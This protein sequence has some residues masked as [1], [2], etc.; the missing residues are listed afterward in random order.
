MWLLARGAKKQNS[1]RHWGRQAVF[2]VCV[3]DYLL[4]STKVDIMPCTHT[5]THTHTSVSNKES[6]FSEHSQALSWEWV[7]LQLS[8]QNKPFPE[9]LRYGQIYPA[10]FLP[11]ISICK[12]DSGIDL[13]ITQNT[14]IC[15][16]ILRRNCIRSTY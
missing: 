8:Q 16:R 12:F 6:D 10:F 9:N 7:F 2:S 5:H 3:A 15:C 13:T 14:K 11:E 1:L 4:A